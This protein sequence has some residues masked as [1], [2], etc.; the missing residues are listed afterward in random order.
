M[1]KQILV[2]IMVVAFSLNAFSQD[3]SEMI[4]ADSTD[5]DSST[6]Y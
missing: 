1:Q 6:N 3:T 2:L 5:K 4:T